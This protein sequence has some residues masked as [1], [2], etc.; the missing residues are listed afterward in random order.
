VVHQGV[1]AIAKERPI[2]DVGGTAIVPPMDVVDVADGATAAGMPAA[3]PVA[4]R[5]RSA[6]GR[7]PYLGLAAQLERFVTIDQV[8][9]DGGVARQLGQGV[10]VEQPT[11]EQLGPAAGGG[12]ESV[13]IGD[14][15]HHVPIGPNGV[16]I[17]GMGGC[18]SDHVHE[19]IGSPLPPRVERFFFGVACGSVPT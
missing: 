6:L 5:D 13:D 12:A 3:T 11:T 10:F 14:G 9:D 4:H 1:V 7:V 19:G 18:G 2:A 8:C 16:A 17:F 15:V